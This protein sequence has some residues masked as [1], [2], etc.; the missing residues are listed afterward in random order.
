MIGITSY[1]AYIPR[2]RLDRMSI[3][4]GI[5][6]LAPAVITVAQ[7]ERSFCNWDEDSVTMAVAAAKD[8]LVGMDKENV[9]A[10]YLA[11]TTLPFEDRLNAG[12][13]STALNLREDILAADFTS[14]LKAGTSSVV[15]ALESIKGGKKNQILVAAAEK[16]EAKAACLSEM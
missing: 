15:T 12:I 13:V 11:S 9:G 6:W 3:F 2:L 14:S 1:G 5:G 4:Q 16:R 8:C 7:G 10:L